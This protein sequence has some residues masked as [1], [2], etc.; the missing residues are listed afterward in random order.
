MS[1]ERWSLYRDKVQ[2]IVWTGRRQTFEGDPRAGHVLPFLRQKTAAQQIILFLHTLLHL[3]PLPL[4][5]S[6]VMPRQRS[7]IPP[8]GVVF[9]TWVGVQVEE[10][11][12]APGAQI[13]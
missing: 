2:L 9:S 7:R 8:R 11:S 1:W 13:P 5:T 4:S 6:P 12:G 10:E 3:D